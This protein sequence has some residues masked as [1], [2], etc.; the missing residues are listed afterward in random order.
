MVTVHLIEGLAIN[1]SSIISDLKGPCLYVT[2]VGIAPHPHITCSS[3]VLRGICSAT[4]L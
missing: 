4:E 3:L 2:A 1:S